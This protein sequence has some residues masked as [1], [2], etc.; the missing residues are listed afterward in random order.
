M[1]KDT[2]LLKV[3]Y[4]PF[5][6]GPVERAIPATL[7]QREMWSTLVL[8][9]EANICY[10]EVI[11]M[12]VS[13]K[14][15]INKIEEAFQELLK[16]HEALRATF[17]QDGKYFVVHQYQ[18]QKIDVKTIQLNELGN[19]QF[20]A[21]SKPFD[22][23]NGPLARFKV[24]KESEDRHYLIFSAHHIIC[25][26]WSLAIILT[27]LT[28]AYENINLGPVSSFVEFAL[29]ENKL[30]ISEKDRQ[31]WLS[32][33]AKPFA[34]NKL[35]LD[36]SR[37]KYRTYESDRLDLDVSSE[38]VVRLKKFSAKNRISF[39]TLL[40]GSF[41]LLLKQLSQKN[42]VVV[43]MATA[44]QSIPGNEEIVGHLVN[45]LPIRSQFN[46]MEKVTDYL[47]NLK[48]H[49]MDGIDHQCY[50]FGSL[51]QDLNIPRNPSEI[52]LINVVFNID[53]QLSN[54][55]LEFSQLKA[56]YQSVPRIK[57]N[58][59]IFINAVS[60]DHHL[61]I[62]CQYNKNL[63][64]NETVKNW[65][66]NYFGLL[67][68]MISSDLKV[69]DISLPKL[70]IPKIV[71][72][73]SEVVEK[74]ITRDEDI[75]RKLSLIW[76]ELLKKDVGIDDNFFS[77]GGH[78]LL[79]VEM[80]QE[81]EFI[82][83]KKISV[84]QVFENPTVKELSSVLAKH[85]VEKAEK[86]IPV[87][88]QHHYPVTPAQLQVWYLE[89]IFKSTPMH[90]LPSSIDLRFKVD[91]ALLEEAIN[92]LIKRH[93]S[94]RSLVEVKDGLPLSLIVDSPD[95]FILEEV[96]VKQNEV[97]R[98]LNELASEV[99][100]KE[101]LFLF[102]AKLLCISPDHYVFFFMPH[103]MI[104]DGWSFDIFFEELNIAYTSLVNEKEPQF[105]SEVLIN[106]KDYAT[107]LNKQISEN[108][109]AGEKNFWSEKLKLPLPLIDLTLKPRPPQMIHVGKTFS[110]T[111][112]KNLANSLENYCLDQGVS[113]FNVIL[114]AFKMALA[115]KSGSNDVIVGTPVRCRNFPELLNVIGYFV[116]TVALRTHIDPQKKFAD[117]LK[118]VIKTSIEA[119]DHSQLPYQ[120]VMKLIKIPR[121]PS[122][123][124]IYQTFFSYQ[125]VSNRKPELAG[126]AYQQINIDKNSTHTDLDLWIKASKSKVEGAFEYRADL[127]DEA[128]ISSFYQSFCQILHEVI[129]PVKIDVSPKYQATQFEWE[130][131]VA[132][133]EKSA[134]LY[135][136]K[137]A[138]KSDLS[139]LSYQELNT[140]A[141]IYAHTLI[142]QGI[143]TGS[144]V[145]I[146]LSRHIELLP[147]LLGILKTG[148]AYVP[149]DPAF[150]QDRLDYMIENSQ[151]K[152]L[153]TESKH[154]QRFAQVKSILIENIESNSTLK[155]NPKVSF[156]L[157]N[158][159]YVIYTSGS[160]G[161]PKGVEISH[162]SLINFLLSMSQTPGMK[163]SDRLLAVTTLSFDIAGLELFLPLVNGA[164][165]YL[166]NQFDVMDGQALKDIISKNSINYMQATPSTWRL[167]LAAGWSGDPSFKI[168][169]GGEAFPKDLAYKLIPMVDS[170][171]NMYG[172]T[173]TTIW[174]T[175]KKLS[176]TDAN[177]TVGN[178]IANTTLYILDESKNILPQGEEGELYIGGVGVAK[179]YYN[180][181]DLTQ[182]RFINHPQSSELIY[183]TGDLARIN[184]FGELE[185]LGRLD[186]QV[187]VRG[188]RI[189]LGEIEA[190]LNMHAGVNVSAA[191]TKEVT[192]GDARIIA[193]VEC[194]KNITMDEEK[195]K[196]HLSQALPKYMIP[197]HF[198][199]IEKMPQT[200]NGKIDKKTL[201]TIFQGANDTDKAREKTS[202]DSRTEEMRLIWQKVLEVKSVKD[203]D[204]FFDVG[205]NSLLAVTLSNKVTKHFGVSFQLRLLLEKPTFADFT[206]NYL[207][208]FQEVSDLTQ[209]KYLVTIRK[210]GQLPPLFCI[211]PVGGNVLNYTQLLPGIE[212]RPVY[213]IQSAG[214]VQNDHPESIEGLA[215]LYIK[216]MK[217]VQPH[218]PYLLAGGSMGGM[219]A[220]EIAQQL[221]EEGESISHLILFDTFGPDFDISKYENEEIS[222]VENA[223]TMLRYHTKKIVNKLKRM[224]F[225]LLGAEYTLEMKLFDLEVKNYQSLWKYRPKVYNGDLYLFRNEIKEKG[226]YADP[227]LGWG[228]SV[229]G[230]IH[231]H[232]IK[233]PH[234]QFIE[235]EELL[236]AL[237][238]TI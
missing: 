130:S 73:A 237:K 50:T 55:G 42:D 119:F 92:V 46:E 236:T 188:Y 77:K 151:I 200:L 182:E 152:F 31:Y 21:I 83:N 110:F 114:T 126:N 196:E 96:R 129:P 222:I 44:A 185:V 90:N 3:Q 80:I 175:C 101:S 59:E 100:P 228:N 218:G 35:P 189:E 136:D 195:L 95:R 187:K 115:A 148:A 47:Q 75:E 99:I 132:F 234:G 184:Q 102:R 54:Q 233:A 121:D 127:F 13:G 67:E 104:W 120:E 124:P 193:F 204:N 122:R 212:N 6:S 205:G 82:F 108:K 199:F 86:I 65:L 227:Y 197:S 144:Y 91:S 15:S 109:L 169:C 164:S 213:G 238:K 215:S 85:K 17:S 231:T 79:V 116:N 208:Q 143:G 172:P 160:T 202:E 173:E 180:R 224:A 107:W 22:L 201:G 32:L 69:G 33:F 41:S 34:G 36:F 87:K 26:G 51:L 106:Y 221:K 135:S 186:G 223:F 12:E 217:L 226:W 118:A 154:A 123:T 4:D 139:R 113:L 162:R 112:D 53:Q 2:S 8:E 14:L 49:M 78:S 131:V 174:S 211:H 137:F 9:P 125:D 45:M 27:E 38:L 5:R 176:L 84:R 18:Y 11:C 134:S 61:T 70:R 103:H 24:L 171:W 209:T 150:P 153:I 161:K 63:F 10:N 68:M 168:L 56:S 76:K 145:G 192:P 58:F 62:E 155:E 146:A 64:K 178:A 166:A 81:I 39:Y 52:P 37:P 66:E 60:R 25:D 220:Y 16:R 43:G 183:A 71:S 19:H 232:Y 147:A 29:K 97:Q 216:E 111:L 72:S 156:D 40:M 229:N 194:E 28:R 48:R 23:V 133:F 1:I 157:E 105:K 7:S 207:K 230:K 20:E 165:I 149:L 235:S 179:G 163:A 198:V 167:L 159:A 203:D 93:E 142:K 225:D 94:L 141:N 170:V 74:S 117:N 190:Q 177:I 210:H 206:E 57:E 30:G 219:I 214:L 88:K 128:W 140:R 181:P 191:I 158:S 89:E 138:I 98:I